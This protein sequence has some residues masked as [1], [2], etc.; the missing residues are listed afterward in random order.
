MSRFPANQ[1]ISISGKGKIIFP[2]AS[3]NHTHPATLRFIKNA[4]AHGL[5]KIAEG[6][7]MEPIASP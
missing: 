5:K 4:D 6:N 7:S 2:P 3:K 1:M